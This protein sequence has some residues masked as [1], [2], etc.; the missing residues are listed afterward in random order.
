MKWEVSTRR[1]RGEERDSRWERNMKRL[2]TLW[3]EIVWNTGR[4]SRGKDGDV[5][6]RDKDNNRNKNDNSS[7][8]NNRQINRMKGPLT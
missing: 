5:K 6:L 8:T 7:T 2:W 1:G 3:R 4:Y